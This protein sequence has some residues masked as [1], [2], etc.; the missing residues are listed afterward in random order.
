MPSRK[1]T[2]VEE[3]G[4]LEGIRMRRRRRRKAGKTGQRGP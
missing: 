3:K 2:R 4:E 1:V